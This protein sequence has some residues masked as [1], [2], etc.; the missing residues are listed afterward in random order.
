MFF[1][2]DV[3]GED[4]L[5]KDY[6]ICISDNGKIIKGFKFSEKIVKIISSKYGQGMYRYNKSKKGKT[7]LKIRIYLVA[8]YYI[9]KSLKINENLCLRICRDF[10]GR[11]E[12]IKNNLK[13]F[14]EEKLGLKCDFEFTRLGKDSQAHQY[15]YLMRKDKKNKLNTYVKLNLMDLEKW[16]K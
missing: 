13:Y 7:L 3:S 5:S 6:T 12:E 9:I 10:D 15:S 14:L 2:I 11:E 16:L 4:L 1:E 8:I